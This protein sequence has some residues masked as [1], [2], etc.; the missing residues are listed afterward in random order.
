METTANSTLSIPSFSGYVEDRKYV[1]NVSPKTLAW[2]QDAWKPFGPYL[3]PVL[4]S[5]GRIG[6]GLKAAGYDA[7]EEGHMPGVSQQL[8][9][10]VVRLV[11]RST[12]LERFASHLR[13]GVK[14][15]NLTCLWRPD[16]CYELVPVGGSCGGGALACGFS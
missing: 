4:A 7:V 16:S 5:G 2:L 10:A 3:E 12:R 6:D 8:S 15:V 14:L 13:E 9:R 1:K 11:V